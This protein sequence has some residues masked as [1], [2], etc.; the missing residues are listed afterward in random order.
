MVIR[1]LR[2]LFLHRQTD[3][4]PDG[5]ADND[6]QQKRFHRHAQK[7]DAQSGPLQLENDERSRSIAQYQ[8]SA[9]HGD[10]QPRTPLVPEDH[11]L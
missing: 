9:D 10:G 6:C 2:R 1:F 5:K 7:R 4:Q 8:Q 3:Q 11:G